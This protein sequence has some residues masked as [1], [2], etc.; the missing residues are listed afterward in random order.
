VPVAPRTTH[1]IDREASRAGPRYFTSDQPL[2]TS[3][4]HTLDLTGYRSIIGTALLKGFGFEEEE[5]FS[6][7]PLALRSIVSYCVPTYDCMLLDVAWAS[8][9][10]VL[11]LKASAQGKRDW[12]DWVI[13]R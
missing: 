3:Q 1:S 11:R 12:I 2:D 4:P 6:T 9:D 7:N 13:L 5:S 10:V 8:W